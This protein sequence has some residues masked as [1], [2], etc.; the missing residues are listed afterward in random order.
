MKNFIA[1]QCFQ[2][3]QEKF[4]DEKEIIG[5]RW[6]LTWQHD[7][8]QADGKKAKAR[9]IVSGFQDTSAPTPSK[10]GSQLFF[11][12]CAWKKLR[13]SKG[14]VSGAFLQGET[15]NDPLWCRPPEMC[16]E[17][18]VEEE[19]TRVQNRDPPSNPKTRRTVFLPRFAAE[20]NLK[21]IPK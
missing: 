11:Q 6:L 17:L 10:A 19:T 9:A 2:K 20:V 18:G 5:M 12:L 7:R 13:I 1:A 15:L 21:P 4:P 3:A 8:S 14:D 16:R